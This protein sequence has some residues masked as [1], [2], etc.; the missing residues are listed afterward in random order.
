MAPRSYKL[1]QISP[2]EEFLVNPYDG[3]DELFWIQ[4]DSDNT[5][6]EKFMV[7]LANIAGTCPPVHKTEIDST[8]IF[9]GKFY[10]NS[11]NKNEINFYLAPFL[12]PIFLAPRYLDPS[13]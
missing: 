13:G 1:K 9:L 4:L 8:K 3:N 2:D 7:E 10:K 6:C 12:A 5:P 11:E